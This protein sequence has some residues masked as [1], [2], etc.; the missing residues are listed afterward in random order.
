[1]MMSV[2]LRPLDP[3]PGSRGR[4]KCKCLTCDSVVH[5]TLDNVKNGSGCRICAQRGGDF[6]SPCVV[7]VLENRSLRSVKVGIASQR[8]RRVK[9][10]VAAKWN[11]VALFPFDDRDAAREVE[12]SVLLHVRN[13]LG[14][15]PFLGPN[16][17]GRL[18]GWSETSCSDEISSRQLV[19]LVKKF[20]NP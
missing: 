8:S 3:Y 19:D 5:P 10:F 9:K 7:Y 16:D 2:G 11:E 14:V 13:E 4:W 12:Q 18:G 1:M 20:T 17:M 15:P 6:S